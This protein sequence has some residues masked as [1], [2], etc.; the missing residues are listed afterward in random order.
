MAG[1][2]VAL[3]Y[4]DLADEEDHYEDA[5]IEIAQTRLG[6]QVGYRYAL[7]DTTNLTGALEFASYEWEYNWVTN[8][9]NNYFYDVEDDGVNL[10]LGANTKINDKLTLGGSLSAGFETGV[11]AY[12][13]VALTPSV[14]VKTSYSRVSYELGEWAYRPVWNNYV[15]V[16]GSALG[17]GDMQFN[18]ESMRVSL[19]YAF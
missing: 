12:M 17:D 1:V 6:A 15:P 8:S 3:D 10:V 14:S 2:F 18:D 5:S 11:S 19:N 4:A 9:G 13:V 16:T 7:N